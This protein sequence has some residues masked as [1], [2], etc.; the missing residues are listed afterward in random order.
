MPNVATQ[1]KY[2]ATEGAVDA[3]DVS[4]QT[5]DAVLNLKRND[6]RVVPKYN[7]RSPQDLSAFP[8][9]G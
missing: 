6:G 3:D 4:K 2:L 1:K 8:A 9:R 7:L 5:I